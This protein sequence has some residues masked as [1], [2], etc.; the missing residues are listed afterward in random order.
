MLQKYQNNFTVMP[1]FDHEKCDD[2]ARALWV[3]D[4]FTAVCCDG[5]SGAKLGDEG[6]KVLVDKLPGII[7]ERF[8]VW[9]GNEERM[10]DELYRI[11]NKIISNRARELGAK[12]DDL[13]TTLT[14]FAFREERRLEKGKMISFSI[15][16]G[17]VSGKTWKK[18]Y[19]IILHPSNEDNDTS[20]AYGFPCSEKYK[21]QIGIRFGNIEDYESVFAGTD[22]FTPFFYDRNTA[23]ITLDPQNLKCLDAIC[24]QSGNV[25]LEN[26]E[27]DLSTILYSLAQ[28]GRFADDISIAIASRKKG[29]PRPDIKSLEAYYKKCLEIVPEDTKRYWRQDLPEKKGGDHAKVLAAKDIPDHVI[30]PPLPDPEPAAVR[31]NPPLPVPSQADDAAKEKRS[32]KIVLTVAAGFAV[33]L[34]AVVFSFVLL[35]GKINDLEKD[36]TMLT[37][38]LTALE[39]Q[40]AES[41]SNSSDGL[42]DISSMILELQS[43]QDGQS[44]I[45]SE[46]ELEQSAANE[47]LGNISDAVDGIDYEQIVTETIKQLKEDAEMQLL[48][49]LPAETGVPDL[50]EEQ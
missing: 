47:K 20:K 23:G 8:H 35:S 25:N 43:A 45:I 19:D 30:K 44:E 11:C 15:G 31:P 34:S 28:N 41:E 12:D 17:M 46:I 24:W 1:A 16:D 32:K 29:L 6:A 13:Y 26:R 27:L 42:N 50:A 3:N 9:Y 18:R 21:R 14:G 40:Q 5:T 10:Q 2:A 38:Q 33:L 22:G 39:Q 48:L 7:A 4:V 49:G 37:E 36:N